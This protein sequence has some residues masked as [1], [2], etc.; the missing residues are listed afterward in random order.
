MRPISAPASSA[1]PVARVKLVHDCQNVMAAS[2]F[3]LKASR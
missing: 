3:A 2:I 1:L